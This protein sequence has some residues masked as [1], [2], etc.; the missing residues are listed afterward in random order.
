MMR[1]STVEDPAT[2]PQVDSQLENFLVL[3]VAPYRW[4][5]QE[6]NSP[7]FRRSFFAETFDMKQAPVKK[8]TK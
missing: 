5:I 7:S 8:A 4:C 2:P 3:K 1:A 6:T